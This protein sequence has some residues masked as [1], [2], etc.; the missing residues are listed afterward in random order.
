MELKLISKEK[1]CIEIELSE[2]DETILYLLINQLL[3]DEAVAE[4]RYIVGYPQLDKPKV[5]VRVKEGKPQTALKRAAKNLASQFEDC[6]KSL[7]KALK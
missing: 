6:R 5:F 2:M 1:D 7:E 3:S 4:A